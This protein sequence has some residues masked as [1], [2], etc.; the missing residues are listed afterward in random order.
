MLTSLVRDVE[1]RG[2]RS[3]LDGEVVTSDSNVIVSELH[4]FADS[5]VQIVQLV[6][7]ARLNRISQ[8]KGS[9]LE[10]LS[11]S[12]ICVLYQYGAKQL[13]GEYSFEQ[14]I[15]TSNMNFFFDVEKTFRHRSR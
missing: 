9:I 11:M 6:A 3:L 15:N 4:T 7:I 8:E 13:L 2:G 5:L 12:N 1:K 14:C 10:I